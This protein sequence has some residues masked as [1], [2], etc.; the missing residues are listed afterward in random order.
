[1]KKLYSGL[2]ALSCIWG[3]SF[4]FIKIL[5]DSLSV[6]EVVFW[7]CLFGA[8]VLWGIYLWKEKVQL[9][10]LPWG[11]LA[12]I[13]L[14]NNAIPWGMIALSETVISSSLASVLNATT[15]IFTAI[16]GLLFFSRRL[17][18]MQWIGILIGFIGIFI[19]SDVSGNQFT[20]STFIGVGTMLVAT[21]CYGFS[22][23]FTKKKLTHVSS[24]ALAAVTLTFASF[25]S[26]FFA[27]VRGTM[28]W[29]AILAPEVF[30]SFIGLGAFGSGI[31][32]FLL[33]FLIQE[34]TAEFAMTV[35]YLVPITAILWGAIF[36]QE[37]I[38]MNMLVGLLF[39]FLGVYLS[40][41]KKKRK[42][43]I[44]HDKSYSVS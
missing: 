29:S 20:S 25:Y 27:M 11:K 40:G 44:Q 28:N 4:L 24:V 10:S 37:T 32:I 7:R 36:L 19:L 43:G 5:V 9:S 2:I 31:A 42:R 21:V 35:T 3:T 30:G 12:L 41:E 18:G 22:S 38:T 13:G 14:T 39:V 1:M 8:V 23:Q 34:G 33:Y 15:P 6:W 26:L 16:I 17:K